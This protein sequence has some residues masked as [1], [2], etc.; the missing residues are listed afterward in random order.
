MGLRWCRPIVL[1]RKSRSDILG[2]LKVAMRQY[3]Y[4]GADHVLFQGKHHFCWGGRPFLFLTEI[5]DLQVSDT[6]SRIH[7][8]PR[9][10]MLWVIHWKSH[11]NLTWSR[12]VEFCRM[13]RP[14]SCQQSVFLNAASFTCAMSETF[15]EVAW[16]SCQKLWEV[17]E[18]SVIRD[19]N[20]PWAC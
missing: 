13:P 11:Q 16:C 14:K 1:H 12:V 19:S 6:C 15:F 17:W 7:L 8:P 4:R 10:Q 20:N 18:W 9:S 3:M 2:T 5:Y